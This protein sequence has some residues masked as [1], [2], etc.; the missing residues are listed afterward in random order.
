[1]AKECA[2]VNDYEVVGRGGG[3]GGEGGPYRIRTV[4]GSG[5]HKKKERNERSYGGVSCR[6]HNNSLSRSSSFFET[7]KAPSGE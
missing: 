3:G 6:A 7:M 4:A 2:S 5:I 1:L